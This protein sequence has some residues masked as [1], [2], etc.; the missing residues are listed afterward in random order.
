MSERTTYDVDSIE[1]ETKPWESEGEGTWSVVVDGDEDEVEFRYPERARDPAL[2]EIVATLEEL[3]GSEA[4]LVAEVRT[5]G[6]PLD[7]SRDSTQ[8]L[9]SVSEAEDGEESA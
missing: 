4:G 5:D 9:V 3:E 2:Q 8:T 1:L 7:P 6:A